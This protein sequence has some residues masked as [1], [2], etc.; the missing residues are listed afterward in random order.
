[1]S[2][3][4]SRSEY[5]SVARI[6]DLHGGQTLVLDAAPGTRVRVVVGDIWLTQEGELDDS[7]LR[8]GESMTLDASPRTVIESFGLTRLEI[9]APVAVPAWRAWMPGLRQRVAAAAV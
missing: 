8:G 2:A 6:V 5:P 9:H 7:F 4:P 1:M 3:M